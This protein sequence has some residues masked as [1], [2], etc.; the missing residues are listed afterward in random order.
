MY[1]EF[2]F[3]YEHEGRSFDGKTIGKIHTAMS[4]RI[5]QDDEHRRA[6]LQSPPTRTTTTS[7]STTSPAAEMFR[8]EMEAY[9]QSAATMK[10]KPEVE[11][12]E[13]ITPER[14][15]IEREYTFRAVE[16]TGPVVSIY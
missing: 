8:R 13:C 16:I 4:E 7:P 12:E 6:E 1:D 15:R 9:M 10:R 3:R 14:E 2:D 5:L 11:V